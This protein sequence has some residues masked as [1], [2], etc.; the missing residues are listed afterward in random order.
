[1]IWPKRCRIVV[2]FVCLALAGCAPA[3]DP[4]EVEIVQFNPN[5]DGRRDEF[6]THTIVETSDGGRYRVRGEWGKPGDTFI[7]DRSAVYWWDDWAMP[8]RL[9]NSE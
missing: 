4:V 7:L 9:E 3:S 8:T 5:V 6:Y 2:I 1:M